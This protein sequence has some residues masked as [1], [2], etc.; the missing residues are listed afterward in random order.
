MVL[1]PS[2]SLNLSSL[3]SSKDFPCLNDLSFSIYA[4]R[5]VCADRGQAYLCD[6]YAFSLR[7]T[8]SSGPSLSKRI[9]TLVKDQKGGRTV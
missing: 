3:H 6:A 7:G 2:V 4:V 1:S 5:K 9:R 8:A